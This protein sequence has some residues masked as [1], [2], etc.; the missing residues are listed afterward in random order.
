MS[1]LTFFSFIIDSIV[2]SITPEPNNIM[3]AASG[4]NFGLKKSIPHILGI[5]F[6][7]GVMV[8]GHT[9]GNDYNP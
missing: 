6:G 8:Y 2:T 1:L 9:W 4:L 7:F 5:S 3:S